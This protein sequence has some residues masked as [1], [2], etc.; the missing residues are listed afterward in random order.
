MR[1]PLTRRQNEALDFLTQYFQEHRRS[2]KYEEICAGLGVKSSN[3]VF[4]LLNALEAK[5]YIHRDKH[6]PRS[7]RLVDAADGFGA[8]SESVVDLMLVSRTASHEPARLRQRPTDYLF[9]DRYFLRNARDEEAC[10]LLRTSDDGMNDDGIRKGD[11]AVVEERD[12]QALRNG[13][14]VA[15]ILGESMV[16]RRFSFVND[17]LHFKPANRMYQD[18]QFA[19]DDPACFIIGPVLGVLRRF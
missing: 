17:R 2:P 10:L 14:L 6:T 4:K 12:W 7:L 16:V 15:V 3:A 5:G 1:Q 19:V 18:D 13:S 8:S 11:L 9:L